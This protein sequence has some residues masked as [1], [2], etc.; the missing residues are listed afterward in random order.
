MSTSLT[1]ETER[2]EGGR[3]IAEVIEPPGAMTYGSTA[4]E[5]TAKAQ[6]LALRV[7]AERLK[8]QRGA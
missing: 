1:I 2:V 3:W 5:A 8:G 4:T 7:L 6:G